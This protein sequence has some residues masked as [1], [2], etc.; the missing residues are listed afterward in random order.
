MT[1][2]IRYTAIACAVLASTLVVACGERSDQTAGQRLD[3]AVSEA[4]QAGK[5]MREDARQA[6]QEIRQEAQEAGKELQA[7]GSAASNAIA[8]NT[9][10]AAITA[11]VN[12]AL[13]GDTQLSALAINVD[14]SNGTVELK[15]T[16]PTEAARD[17]AT[18]LAAAVEGVTKVDNKLTVDS[19]G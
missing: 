10:D 3:N 5:E 8:N 15:G 9:A 16:A 11:K 18:T 7:A 4:Q 17:R 19:K 6:G 2:K 1:P 14:T 13:A 12:A